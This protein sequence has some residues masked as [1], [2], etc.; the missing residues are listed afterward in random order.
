MKK[1]AKK[2][3]SSRFIGTSTMLVLL[4]VVLVSYQNCVPAKIANS[5]LG[6]ANHAKAEVTKEWQRVVE[7]LISIIHLV[8]RQ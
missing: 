7:P 2:F 3:N 4:G 6:T 1:K 8:S 5:V